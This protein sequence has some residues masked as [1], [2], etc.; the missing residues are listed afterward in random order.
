M[1]HRYD[2]YD[3]FE[4]PSRNRFTDFG[5]SYLSRIDQGSWHHLVRQTLGAT[6]FW[7][8]I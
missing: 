8:R 7:F 6:K 2:S 4:N 5:I 1:Q 3:R